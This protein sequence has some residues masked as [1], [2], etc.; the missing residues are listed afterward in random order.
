MN[1]TRGI[2]LG[3]LIIGIA[4]FLIYEGDAIGMVAGLLSGLGIG[5][6]LTG[7]LKDWQ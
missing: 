4:L 2:G 3:I 6:L 5:L 1:K 7:R